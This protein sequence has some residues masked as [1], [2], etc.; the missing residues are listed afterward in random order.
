MKKLL[1]FLTA[2]LVL[3]SCVREQNP[4]Y[5][6]EIAISVGIG[7]VATRAASEAEETLLTTI[8]VQM[9]DGTEILLEAW[10]S[11]TGCV[12]TFD[13]KGAQ[14]N[15]VS[16]L[17]STYG[18][19][20]TT[21]Y[22]RGEVYHYDFGGSTTMKDVEVSYTGDSEKAWKFGD[23]TYYWPDEYDRPLT[24]CSYAPAE[25]SGISS[26]VLSDNKVQFDYS[27]PESDSEYSV[28]EV[29]RDILVG[30][31]PGQSRTKNHGNA[32]VN[33]KHALTSVKFVCKDW[34][35]VKV[36]SI[37]LE[38]F[39]SSGHASFDGTSFQWT[40]LAGKTNFTQSFATT[41]GGDKKDS[42]DNYL[43]DDSENSVRT[44]MVIPQELSSDAKITVFL[45]RTH[46]EVS[47]DIT[48]LSDLL[49]NQ[50][51]GNPLSNWSG[52]AGKTITFKVNNA[53][54]DDQFI[55][56]PLEGG[57]DFNV[58]ATGNPASDF[59][60][61]A[62]LVVN[63]EDKNHDVLTSYLFTGDSLIEGWLSFNV[64]E[65]NWTK[66]DDGFYYYKGQTETI[67]SQD[68]APFI[69]NFSFDQSKISFTDTSD[70]PTKPEHFEAS[71][72]VQGCLQEDFT[73]NK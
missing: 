8:P 12:S 66:G 36:D 41:P 69:T 42:Y 29:Q 9:E 26:F 61:R 59:S 23:R 51:P 37:R 35:G 49:D 70:L 5:G 62:A 21:V 31:D 15:D 17:A 48:K 20:L 40:E 52:Y 46:G 65:S 57:E 4:F 25:N 6:R 2:A 71:I 68:G 7:R 19:F 14:L 39:Y 47:I 63:I 56:V 18:K 60:V 10:L 53:K 27:T 24:F 72:I 13:T 38:N 32:E 43:L 50:T 44:F 30:L 58:K 45:D 22:E 67:T 11:D 33:F 54:I 55:V 1:V 34:S 3:S 28:A 73:W 64:D 16:D